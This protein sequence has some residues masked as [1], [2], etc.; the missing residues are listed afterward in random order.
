M[1]L[2][3]VIILILLRPNLLRLDVVES[4]PLGVP[5]LTFYVSIAE[6]LM[7]MAMEEMFKFKII[8][9]GCI[10]GTWEFKC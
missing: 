5:Y 1:L 8:V 10:L 7:A 4:K 9:C 6:R 3:R 2:L